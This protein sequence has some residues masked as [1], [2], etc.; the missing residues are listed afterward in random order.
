MRSF[1]QPGGRRPGPF[2]RSYPGT[3]APVQDPAN[4]PP[5]SAPPEALAERLAECETRLARLE[6]YL[7]LAPAK[8]QVRAQAPAGR[9]GEELEFV[10]GQNWFALVGIVVLATGVAFTLS[11]PYPDLPAALPSLAG[12]AAA[13]TLFALAGLWRRSFEVLSG[14]L[15][16]AAMALLYFSAL[17]LCF[18]GSRHVLDAASVPGAAALAAAAGLNFAVAARRNSPLLWGL[19]LAMGYATALAVGSD[20]FAL[21]AI[22]AVSAAA[23]V[24]GLRHGWPALSLAIVPLGY[25]A[26][27]LWALNNPLL[28]R[29]C[30]IV[31]GFRAGLVFLLAIAVI[32][33][34][35]PPRAADGA[36]EETLS[37]VGALI[38]CGAGYG[39]FL[40]HSLAWLDSRFFLA[41]HAGAFL[42]FLGL[43]VRFG[44]R[45]QN[46]V[47][48][49]LYA[50]TGYLAL[51]VAIIRAT[52]V[53]EVFVWLSL[54][55]VVV[56]ATAVYFRSRFIVVAN[57]LIFVGIM[58][59]YLALAR[60]ESG[61]SLGFGLVALVTARL[62]NWKRD[63]LELKTEVM[64]N[65]YLAS[66]FLVFPYAL[67]HL[68]PAAYVGLAWVAIALGYYGLNLIVRNRKYRWMGHGTLLMT[69]L[70]L[71]IAGIGRL[72]P[73]HRNLSL[74]IL[75]VVLLVVSLIF[76]T[77][78]V[79]QRS[80][81]ASR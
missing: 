34:W 62:L 53:P 51:S 40:L 48:T 70:Y 47:S 15:R 9:T 68:V 35:G 12:F 45:E 50:M 78:R 80:K 29:P 77:L 81:P 17:R 43:A 33:S 66:A 63:R 11:L 4:P 65:A 21:T 46:R 42:V 57:F 76:T 61:I 55:S 10:V 38:N 22:T 19:A 75:G 7:D 41:A 28:G 67:Y 79:R 74:L 52:A 6:A 23:V 56:A 25:A 71:M 39:L 14:Y 31:S 27:L 73:V 2:R 49:F 69:A 20:W 1:G 54:Q 24:V 32:F 3:P 64:R 16:G 58:A 59:A 36:R 13:A 8:L 5:R 26:Y 60:S 72:E 30:E 37:G 44:A 18:F